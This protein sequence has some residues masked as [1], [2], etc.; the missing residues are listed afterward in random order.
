MNKIMMTLAI[1]A[2]GL[3][4]GACGKQEE[5]SVQSP[6]PAPT[7]QLEVPAAAAPEPM[8]DALETVVEEAE[9]MI[10]EV[11]E[12][13][14]E[15]V[16]SVAEQAE[17][18]KQAVAEQTDQAVEGAVEKAAAVQQAAVAKVQDTAKMG[19]A[20]VADATQAAKTTVAQ[21]A[22]KVTSTAAVTTTA[23][24]Q[25]DALNLA[26]RS[27]CLAC[28]QVDK[29][30]VGPAWADVA[31]RYRGDASVRDKLVAKVSAGGKGNW[32]D[33]TGGVP[34]PPYSPR[35]ADADIEKLVDF[36]LSL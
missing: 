31:A 19:E 34:M 32:T 22:E 10:E 30:V 33:V 1:S 12:M 26:N 21:V 9:V 7:A 36:I 6:P 24:S 5:Q 16:E 11:S 29:K 3:V 15:T 2:L 17:A 27:G 28:H 23:L 8:A 25:E 14:D 35:V 20:V 18:V 13:V 4:I